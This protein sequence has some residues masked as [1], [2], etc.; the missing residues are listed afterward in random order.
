MTNEFQRQS[1]IA[2]RS[3]QD[4]CKLEIVRAKIARSLADPRPSIVADEGFDRVS[5][6]LDALKK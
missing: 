3:E 1:A 2:E 5:Q 6:L 4:A